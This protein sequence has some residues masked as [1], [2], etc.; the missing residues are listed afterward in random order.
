VF[1]FG[2]DTG[3]EVIKHG[4]VETDGATDFADGFDLAC[5][6]LAQEPVV[7]AGEVINLECFRHCFHL[8]EAEYRPASGLLHRGKPYFW[9]QKALIRKWRWETRQLVSSRSF[10]LTQELDPTSR[11]KAWDACNLNRVLTLLNAQAIFAG[12]NVSALGGEATT[13][14]SHQPLT[15]PPE[16]DV[17]AH[18]VSATRILELSLH[19]SLL[20]FVRLRAGPF[21]DPLPDLRRS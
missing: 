6:R 2:L 8:T 7:P 9:Q 4:R 10:A 21:L 1:G 14:A 11:G 13:P 16:R 3:V 20:H 18:D 12:W 19:F 15:T 5:I 17:S